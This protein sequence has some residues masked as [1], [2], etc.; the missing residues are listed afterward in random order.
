[1]SFDVRVSS[2]DVRDKA[3]MSLDVRHKTT[4]SLDVRLWECRTPSLDVR[5]KTTPSLD[6]RLRAWV[7]GR[8]VV[9]M[10]GVGSELVL[11]G[12]NSDAGL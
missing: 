12:L 11:Y 1:M 7:L 6:V 3:T 8:A 9:L 10:S 4:P 2:L 5:H